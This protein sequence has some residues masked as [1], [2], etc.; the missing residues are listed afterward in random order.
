MFIPGHSKGFKF[1]FIQHQFLL[2]TRVPQT[3][4]GNDLLNH[5]DVGPVRPWFQINGA[6]FWC[7]QEPPCTVSTGRPRVLQLQVDLCT[8]ETG[9]FHEMF[10]LG[11]HKTIIGSW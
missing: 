1:R 6:L 9:D 10:N 7:N 3:N 11:P 8:S 4:G 5:S 2:I